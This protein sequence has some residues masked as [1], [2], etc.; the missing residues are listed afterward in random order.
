MHMI[1]LTNKSI[2]DINALVVKYISLLE[3]IKPEE[4]AVHAYIID[5]AIKYLNT[6][7]GVINKI[8]KSWIVVVVK[9]SISELNSESDIE[10]LI[11]DFIVYHNNNYEAY[12]ENIVGVDEIDRDCDFINIFLN[13]KN[14]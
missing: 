6:Y 4:H 7:F 13:E 2:E 9:K 12:R 10:I 3:S 11:K 8:W 5:Y 1:D 14:R